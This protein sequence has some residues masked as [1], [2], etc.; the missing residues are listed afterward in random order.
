MT[1]AQ[2][3]AAL[4]ELGDLYELDGAVQYR[5]LAY[6]TAARTVREASVSVEQLVRDGRVTELPGIG[7]TL[8]T[9]LQTLVETG[10][11]AQ[12]QKLRA[13]FPSGL[14][15]MTHLPGFG[16]KRARR[17][18]D[19]LGID[20]LEKLRAAAEGQQLRGLRG[21]GAK[22]EEKLLETL[23]AGHD[24]TPTPRW[25]LSRAE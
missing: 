4:D 18:Y 9:K 16:P 15:A 8:E 11:M 10:D 23:A 17:L 21:F 13:Q 24:G 12:S 6:R 25:L 3:A 20:S 22:A 14:I 19:E 7:K 1:N 5:V 2:I